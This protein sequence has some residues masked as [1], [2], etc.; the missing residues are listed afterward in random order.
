MH[1]DH[2]E[3]IIPSD[4]KHLPKVEKF[5]ASFCKKA[6]LTEDQSDNMAIA[7]TELVNNGIIHAHKQDASK[8]V[9]IHVQ[10]EEDRIIVSVQ[11]E[12]E[13]FDPKD[14]ANPTDPQNLWKQSGRGVFLVKN[15]IDEVEIESTPKGTK[16][17]LTEYIP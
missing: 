15:L 14:I 16:V 1:P 6:K 7:V 13:G 17:T 9:T 10:Y 4:F 5:I 3:L 12:G 11:D 8:N 2:E